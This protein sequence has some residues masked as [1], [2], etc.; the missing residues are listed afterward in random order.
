[1]LTF[2]TRPTDPQ[3]VKVAACAELSKTAMKIVE[4]SKAKKLDDSDF[5]PFSGRQLALLLEDGSVVGDVNAMARYLI[6]EAGASSASSSSAPGRLYPGPTA[7]WW[8]EWEEVVLRPA[9]YGGSRADV[10]SALQELAASVSGNGAYL[11]GDALGLE[12]VVVGCTLRAGV[13]MGVVEFSGELDQGSVLKGYYERF[14]SSPCIDAGIEAVG[15]FKGRDDVEAAVVARADASS[16]VVKK[17]P[18]V[19][20]LLLLMLKNKIANNSL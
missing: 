3:A 9:V 18:R 4:W 20:L 1:M 10:L 14:I 11:A 5:P 7:E 13:L 15:L 2:I 12:D 19:N 16:V 6:C 8:I 17:V